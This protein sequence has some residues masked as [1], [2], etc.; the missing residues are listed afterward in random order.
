[1]KL[2]VFGLIVT[3]FGIVGTFILPIFKTP[4]D[5]IGYYFFSTVSIGIFFVVIGLF[6]NLF[7]Q[8]KKDDENFNAPLNN[9]EEPR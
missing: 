7:L 8:E 5:G 9:F 2:F 4:Q 6:R 3:I 1:M